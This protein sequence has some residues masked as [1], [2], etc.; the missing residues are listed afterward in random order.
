MRRFLLLTIA[1]VVSAHWSLSA[2]ELSYAEQ[3]KINKAVLDILDDYREYCQI[4]DEE[5]RY[6]FLN[7]FDSKECPVYTGDLMMG[8]GDMQ[9]TAHEYASKLL[10][11]AEELSV[12]IKDIKKAEMYYEREKWYIPV[13]FRK[14]VSYLS[15]DVFISSEEYYKQD[16]M[17]NM[18]LCYDNV[19]GECRI[20]GISGIMHSEDLFPEKFLVVERSDKPDYDKNLASNGRPLIFNGFDQAIVKPGSVYYSKNNEDLRIKAD[21]VASADRYKIVKYSYKPIKNRL[22]IYGSMSPAGSID[23]FSGDLEFDSSK[24]HAYEIGADVG[25]TFPLGKRSKGRV[26]VYTGISFSSALLEVSKNNILYS[27]RQG[28]LLRTYDLSEMREGW[29]FTDLSVPV[30]VNFEHPLGRRSPV[31]L[32]W[33]LGA[34]IYFNIGMKTSVPQS[35]SGKVS[36]CLAGFQP[37]WEPFSGTFDTFIYSQRAKRLPCDVSVTGNIGLSVRCFRTLYFNVSGGW[38]YGILKV[39][40]SEGNDWTAS[41]YYPYVWSANDSEDVALSSLANFIRLKRNGLRIKFGLMLKF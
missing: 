17:I 27:Y 11:E 39:L 29:S 18:L 30:Y 26:G 3:R 33:N 28:K 8:Y 1:T 32:F 2:Q 10:E 35:V 7:L 4:Y 15:E 37:D 13:S 16:F 9:I 31:F 41:N 6:L 25:V 21:T 12:S 14:S 19:S 5:Y 40:D 24:S 36:S 38:E 34:K 22:I 20:S 23:M